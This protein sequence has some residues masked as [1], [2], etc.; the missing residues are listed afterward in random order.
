MQA[1]GGEL[2]VSR[3]FSEAPGRVGDSFRL[4]QANLS[5]FCGKE[6]QGTSDCLAVEYRGFEFP[7]TTRREVYEAIH[8]SRAK[9]IGG[10]KDLLPSE[11]ANGL[12]S[13]QH[14][15]RSA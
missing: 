2:A 5:V 7:N 9:V 13:L 3:E 14:D 12:D 1:S 15:L 6:G 10:I 11:K 4:P 8:E